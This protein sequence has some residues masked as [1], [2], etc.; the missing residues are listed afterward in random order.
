LDRVADLDTTLVDLG[1]GAREGLGDV[2]DGDGAEEA[3]ALTGLGRDGDRTGLEVALDRLGGLE[4]VHGA[5]VTRGLDRLDLLGRAL[6]PTDGEV[7]GQQE[8]T[9][10]AVLDVD[11]VAGLAEVRDLVREDE[12]HL[13]SSS[14]TQRPLDV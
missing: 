3:T 12:L 14:C 4:V 5:R 10:V 9:A 1:A 8:V 13:F 11:D 6:R 7:A 2:G